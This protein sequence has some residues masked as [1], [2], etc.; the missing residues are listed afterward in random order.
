M[1][2]IAWLNLYLKPYNGGGRKEALVLGFDGSERSPFDCRMPCIFFTLSPLSLLSS[3]SLFLFVTIK[4]KNK[5]CVKK[6]L[7]RI[8]FYDTKSLFFFSGI[9]NTCLRFGKGIIFWE[10]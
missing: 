4:K 6:N 10:K 8:G 1:G 3:L 9:H 7:S 5:I 2:F